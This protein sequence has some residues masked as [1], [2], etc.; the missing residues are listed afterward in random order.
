MDLCAPRRG[1]TQYMP[2]G[3]PNE[4]KSIVSKWGVQLDGLAAGGQGRVKPTTDCGR[5]LICWNWLWRRWS[6]RGVMAR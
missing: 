1:I 5:A 4:S 2:K 3:Q 6:I